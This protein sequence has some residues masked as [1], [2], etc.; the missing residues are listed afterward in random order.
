ME[1][2][3]SRVV[4]EG[5][6]SFPESIRGIHRSFKKAAQPFRN[7]RGHLLSLLRPAGACTPL[8]EFTAHQTPQQP[9]DLQRFDFYELDIFSVA[10]L[11]R[12][13]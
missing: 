9:P 10:L 2:R 6:S 8:F 7:L 1:P 5:Q 4:L 11:L 3:G 12:L 13:A